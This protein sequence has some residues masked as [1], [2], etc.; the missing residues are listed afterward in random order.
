MTPAIARPVSSSIRAN[1]TRKNSG[2]ATVSRR[3]GSGSGPSFYERV[4][5]NDLQALAQ[6]SASARIREWGDHNLP[7]NLRS[8]EIAGPWL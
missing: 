4:L 8:I 2:S 3:V 5:T 6:I 7:R 1:R